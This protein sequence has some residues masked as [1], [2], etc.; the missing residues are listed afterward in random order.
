MK[1]VCYHCGD[2]CIAKNPPKEPDFCGLFCDTCQCDA[3]EDS[4]RYK[5]LHGDGA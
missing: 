3:C 4:Q 2:L 5:E 1:D